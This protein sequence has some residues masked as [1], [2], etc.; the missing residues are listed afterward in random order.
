MPDPTYYLI[1]LGESPPLPPGTRFGRGELIGKITGLV[2]ILTPILLIGAGG[3]GKNDFARIDGPFVVISFQLREPISLVV[4]QKS[5]RGDRKP[6]DLAP[7][8]RSFLPSKE[9]FITLG[10]AES[11]LDPQ[12]ADGRGIYAI[13]GE[14]NQFS[15]IC[16]CIKSRITTPSDCK[17]LDVPALSLDAA[18]RLLPH[19]R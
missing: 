1:V 13:V 18:R 17:R 3:M 2:G 9:M 6:E 15:N 14:L 10:N 11:S 5:P 8:P 19:L 16:L 7:P 12:G 4:F